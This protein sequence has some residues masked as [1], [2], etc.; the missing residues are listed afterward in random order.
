MI[1]T[2]NS[3]DRMSYLFSRYVVLLTAFVRVDIG[4]W[5]VTAPVIIGDNMLLP[6]ITEVN[7]RYDASLSDISNVG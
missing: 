4:Q 5:R 3:F 6:V 7:G 1:K 2:D